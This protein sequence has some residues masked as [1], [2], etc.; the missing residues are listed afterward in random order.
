MT[1]YADM[2]RRGDLDG[3][4]GLSDGDPDGNGDLLAYRWLHVARDFGH[5]AADELI[6]DLL[7][8]SSL[9]Y[10]DDQFAVGSEHF[11]LGLAYLTGRDGLP[12]DPELAGRHLAEARELGWP[13]HAEG[14]DQLL[15]EAR[16]GLSGPGLTAFTQI[17]G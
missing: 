11:G 3:L 10:D 4:A 15:A 9:R 8:V 12:V 6:D 13:V 1:D 2:A 14:G 16:A 7:E 5:D 17:F